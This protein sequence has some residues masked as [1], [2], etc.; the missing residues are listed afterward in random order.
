[1]KTILQENK[2]SQE[3][4]FEPSM[5]SLRRIMKA[6]LEAGSLCKTKLSVHT[7]INYVRLVHHIVWLERKGFIESIIQDGRIKL[8]L[9]NDGK[10][11]NSML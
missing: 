4:D 10:L 9:T 8:V 2:I 7:K 3:S 11:F 6:M 5:K 1:M